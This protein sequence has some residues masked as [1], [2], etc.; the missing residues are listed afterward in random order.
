MRSPAAPAPT[1]C[2]PTGG[3]GGLNPGTY[4]TTVAGLN[5]ILIVGQGYD[6]SKP[7]YLSFYLHGNS[8]GYIWF[9]SLSNPVNKFV[10][11]HNWIFV[12]P[13]SPQGTS[14]SKDWNQSLNEAF[15]K[16]LEEMFAKYNVCRDIL[17]GSSI[18]GGAIFWTG[19]FFPEEGNKYPA[20][21]SILCGGFAAHNTASRQKVMDLGRDPDVVAKSTFDYTYGDADYL[22]NYI[23][24]SVQ[25]YSDAGFKVKTLVLPG[26]GHCDEWI[27]QG[28]PSIFAQIT[29]DWEERIQELNL[30]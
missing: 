1:G 27:G 2:N 22:Y 11:Q 3:S 9:K 20:H 6:P 15:I 7:T 29:E 23:V 10:N 21:V 30:E 17:I 19:Y 8:G 12:L 18:S 5:A 14:W 28:F 25:L 24:Q 26:A 16:V 4:E 13:R